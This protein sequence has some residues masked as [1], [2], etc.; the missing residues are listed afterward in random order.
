MTRKFMVAAV[1]DLH[2][3]ATAGS[4]SF[5]EMFESASKEADALA[6]CG[7]LT[8]IGAVEEA[9]RLANDLNACTIPVVGVLGNHDHELGRADEVEAT[10]VRAGMRPLELHL[11]EINGVGFVGVKGFGGGFGP[12]MLGAFGESAVKAFVDEALRE[13]S[14]LEHAL[15][16]LM[17]FKSVV[18]VLHYAPIIETL[19][20][21]PPEAY[22]YLGSSRFEEVLNRFDNIKAVFHGHA[23]H[24][25]F[26]GK[27]ARGVPVYNCALTVE[28]PSGRPYALVEVS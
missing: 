15:K 16:Q 9:E 23:H 3:G 24:G 26:Q 20:V 22:T 10:L 2:V 7:D 21:E 19:G 14:K 27:T 5:K 25:S 6:L 13:C 8:N 18:V 11:Q 17:H 12:Y 1:G 28:K 4:R